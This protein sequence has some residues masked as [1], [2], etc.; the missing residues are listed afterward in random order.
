MNHDSRIR[1]DPAH[2]TAEH[3]CRHGDAAGGGAEIWPRHVNEHGA[4]AAGDARPG[5]MVDLDDDVVERVGAGEAVAGGAGRKPDRAVVAAVPRVLAPAVR[6]TDRAARQQHRGPVGAVVPPPYPQR[7]KASRRGGAVPFALVRLDAGPAERHRDPQW[8]RGD[9]PA[10]PVARPR[11]HVDSGQGKAVH[12]LESGIMMWSGP[13]I[14]AR[15]HACS[16]MSDCSICR[17]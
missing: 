1:A 6:R 2:Q 16:F 8:P 11:P 3:G 15:A 13:V 9:P 4:A 12:G 7:P 10:P 17:R 5:V 14:E